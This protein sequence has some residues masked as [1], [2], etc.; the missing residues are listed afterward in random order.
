VRALVLVLAGCARHAYVPPI[1]STLPDDVPIP[2]AGGPLAGP[3]AVVDGQPAP[4]LPP[5]TPGGGALP[6]WLAHLRAQINP[7]LEACLSTGPATIVTG[8]ALL[9]ARIDREGAVLDAELL[10]SSG[11]AP[12]DGCLLQA[13]RA[14]RPKP[15]PPEALTADGQLVTPEMAFR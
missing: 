6:P 9:T 7:L 8:T 10:R 5:D 14:A 2:R 1:P 4:A 3:R 15:P 13:A 11:S 12:Y